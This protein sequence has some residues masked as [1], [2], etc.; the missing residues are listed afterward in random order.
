VAEGHRIH[1]EHAA[2]FATQTDAA[3]LASHGDAVMARAKQQRGGA[4]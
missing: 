1:M 4:S 2:R 3:G